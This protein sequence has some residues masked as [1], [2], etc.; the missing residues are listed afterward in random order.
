M[1][2]GN[3][4]KSIICLKKAKYKRSKQVK[5]HTAN[6]KPNGS[7]NSASSEKSGV[8]SMPMEHIAAMRIQAAFRAFRARKAIRHLRGTVK[9]GTSIEADSV[10]M[11]ALATL[12]H[13]HSWSKIQNQIRERRLY[14]V[15]WCGG[16]ETMEEII[17][18]V[19]QRE[20]AAVKRERAMAYAFSH[21]W[22]ANSGQCFG[23]AYYDLGKESWGW[24]WKERWIAVR[25]WETRVHTQSIVIPNKVQS[26][27]V[28][29]AGKTTNQ[30]ATKIVVSVKPASSNGKVTTKATRSHC[31]SAE[32]RALREPKCEVL[33]LHQS[34]NDEAKTK[35]EK[36]IV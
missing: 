12:S 7:E 13:I 9:F 3:W 6:S 30:P 10:K 18:R 16:A 32:K 36:N 5:V 27:P 24:S 8:I 1:G 34:E 20:E 25:P 33:S 4:F 21:Q 15:E 28:S 35:Q 31:L 29:K 2:S 17:S 14:M 11:Q 22:R 19:Y 23:Q 26:R